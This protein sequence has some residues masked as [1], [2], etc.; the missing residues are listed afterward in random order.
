MGAPPELRLNPGAQEGAG[1]ELHPK[2]SRSLDCWVTPC[3][4]AL[5]LPLCLVVL[6]VL[7]VPTSDAHPE[8][9]RLLACW[10]RPASSA[11]RRGSPTA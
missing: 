9:Q 11:L 5:V 3:N 7:A 6:S 2:A 8:E 4:G 1:P 10:Q